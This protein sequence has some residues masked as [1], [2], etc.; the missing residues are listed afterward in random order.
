M[1][2]ATT[3]R[4]P[5]ARALRVSG[6]PAAAD[7]PFSGGM[8]FVAYCLTGETRAK[9][10]RETIKRAR[11]IYR[12][13]VR[14]GAD[15]YPAALIYAQR[16]GVALEDLGRLIIALQAIDS[17]DSFEA[18]RR[19]SYEDLDAAF[20]DLR[21][22]SELRSIFRLPGEDDLADLGPELRGA[23]LAAVDMLASRWAGQWVS[24]ARGWPL[25][26]RLAKGMRHGSPLIPRDIV[27][28]PPGAGALGAESGDLFDRWV[29][30]V[31]TEHDVAARSL[32]THWSVADI[33]DAT[34]RLAHEAVLDGIAL[35]R[36]ISAAHVGRVTHQY[37][38]VLERGVVK[39][40]GPAQR[41]VLEAGL[42]G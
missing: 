4:P 20:A 8:S 34:L 38:W 42:D 30:L 36:K 7:G 18:L 37:K 22:E 41:R 19:A 2:V 28:S 24:C 13:R 5:G 26:R 31:N 35:A 16:L 23:V 40:L 27:R 39:A 3:L 1:S 9:Q 32:A 25:L 15:P 12:N 6:L 21:E 33:S 11:A 17:S 29:L 14:R 10:R